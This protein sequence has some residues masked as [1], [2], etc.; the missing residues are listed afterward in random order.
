[1]PGFP[2]TLRPWICSGI[3]RRPAS[4][5]HSRVD[6]SI[7]STKLVCFFPSH[8]ALN[9]SQTFCTS[10]VNAK[11]KTRIK[12]SFGGVQATSSTRPFDA[13]ARFLSK[14]SVFISI[15]SF[16]RLQI[17]NKSKPKHG[18]RRWASFKATRGLRSGAGPAADS[19]AN[20]HSRRHA[21]DLAI[22][23]LFEQLQPS[24]R[25]APLSQHGRAIKRDKGEGGSAGTEP[26]PRPVVPTRPG[27]TGSLSRCAPKATALR[28]VPKVP[29]PTSPH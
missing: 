8:R 27:Q 22:N 7:T 23:I 13:S 25:A 20:S 21:R 9:F 11:K 6:F 16:L 24:A 14:P 5:L 3:S 12:S 10:S 15:P 17:I 28:R 26:W 29:S 19:S 18:G 1:M 4:L 2:H